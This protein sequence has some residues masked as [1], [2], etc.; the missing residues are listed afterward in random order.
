MKKILY[1]SKSKKLNA[2]FLTIQSAIDSI[3]SQSKDHY[4]IEVDSGIYY[5]KIILAKPNVTI[6]GTSSAASIITYDDC[7]FSM[8]SDG[9]KLGT[10]RS[11]TFFVDAPNITLSNL[12]IINSSGF[13]NQVGQAIAL[14][15]DGDML[16]VRDCK[17]LG[18]QDTLF[19]G[20]LPKVAIQPNG[21]AGPK[22]HSPRIFTHQYYFN[23]YI[24]GDVD[25]IFGSAFAFFEK[26]IIF[27]HKKNLDTSKPQEN[28]V[29]IH[30]YIT[31]ASTPKEE[32][33][34]YIFYKCK[35]QSDCPKHSVYLGRPWREYASVLFQ[36]CQLGEH[37]HPQGFHDWNKTNFHNTFRFSE[38]QNYGPG[39][40]LKNRATFVA[41][42]SLNLNTLLNLRKSVLY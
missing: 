42:Q 28:E 7:A 12:S 4:T 30:G 35:I 34:G 37:I 21:F 5:E 13:G 25:F 36:Q 23:C 9:T 39:S 16:Q 6:N 41:N 31:A 19:T 2:S 10:F 17:L 24:E 40:D 11:Y 33:Y 8:S 3:P 1:V 20:P 38:G 14:Y 32:P 27:S 22:E 26:C 29:E 15:A 18:H